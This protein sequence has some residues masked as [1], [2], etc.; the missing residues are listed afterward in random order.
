MANMGPKQIIDL[1]GTLIS[2]AS[3]ARG[4]VE[5]HSGGIVGSSTKVPVRIMK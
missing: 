4:A 1:R 3:L 5:A 2:L